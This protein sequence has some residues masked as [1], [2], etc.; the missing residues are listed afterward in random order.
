MSRAARFLRSWTLALPLAAL[1]GTRA[2]AQARSGTNYTIQTFNKHGLEVT[3]RIT[4]RAEIVGEDVR[5]PVVRGTLDNV[6]TTLGRQIEVD[7]EYA[8]RDDFDGAIAHYWSSMQVTSVSGTFEIAGVTNC[9]LYTYAAWSTSR[10]GQ[11]SLC[12]RGQHTGSVSP[13]NIQISDVVVS[14]VFDLIRDVRRLRREARERQQREEREEQ[15]RADSVERAERAR[16][17]SLDRRER[18]RSDS[19]ARAQ[20]REQ[21]RRDSTLRAAR[22]RADSIAIRDAARRDSVASAQRERARQ[23]SIARSPSGREE[24]ARQ[25]ALERAQQ[26]EREQRDRERRDRDRSALAYRMQYHRQLCEAAENAY[27]S[28]DLIRAHKLFSTIITNSQSPSTRSE[29]PP[30]CAEHAQDRIVDANWGLFSQSYVGIMQLVSDAFNVGVGPAVTGFPVPRDDLMGLAIGLSLE[31]GVYFADFQLGNGIWGPLAN[32]LA[33]SSIGPPD[34]SYVGCFG[35]SGWDY[36]GTPCSEYYDQIA[37]APENR[38][39]INWA[40]GVGMVAPKGILDFYPTAAL[41]W[42]STDDGSLVIPAVGFT[43]GHGRDTERFGRIYKGG[44]LRVLMT[45]H[46]ER[47]GVQIGMAWTY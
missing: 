32:A 9:P 13:T 15:A 23:D 18:A 20:Q 36:W 5:P 10:P 14:G 8:D 28:G 4:F 38:Y 29:M 27:R 21:A 26:L 45:R 47:T 39:R 35:P 43:W 46:Q 3:A 6:W 31:K 44:G 12:S 16:Q 37:D 25:E 17:D 34:F 24:R 19:I 2:D 1:L 33:T 40:I 42:V 7:G 30:G 22:T 11:S 41:H